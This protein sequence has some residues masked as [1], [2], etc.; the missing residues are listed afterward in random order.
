MKLAWTY[1]DHDYGVY[2]SD[3]SDLDKMFVNATSVA[4]SSSTGNPAWLLTL[5]KV[6]E[7]SLTIVISLL[8]IVGNQLSFTVLCHHKQKLSTTVVLQALAV[9][10]TLVLIN[11]VL[12]GSMRYVDCAA[13]MDVY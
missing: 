13:Y 9:V 7:V 5:G 3:P 11:L 10:D 1:L 2:N 12:L 6:S 4:P 8:G